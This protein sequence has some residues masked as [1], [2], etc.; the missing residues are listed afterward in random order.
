[1]P[2][3]QNDVPAVAG[4]RDVVGC[5]MPG[6]SAGGGGARAEV[7]HRTQAKQRGGRSHHEGPSQDPHPPPPFPKPRGGS[8]KR[9]DSSCAGYRTGRAHTGITRRST[10][11]QGMLKAIPGVATTA[12]H[13]PAQN[14]PSR[15]RGSHTTRTLPGTQQ[16]PPPLASET[17]DPG[18]TDEACPQ[19]KACT[20]AHP[21]PTSN[22]PRPPPRQCTWA[23]RAQTRGW[24]HL[25]LP[26]M[27]HIT[28]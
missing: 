5:R 20:P 25:T 28:Y 27:Q 23:G 2:K 19:V 16:V 13:P 10:G 26:A 9:R 11:E 12:L 4:R 22:P 15:R 7:T 8:T 1:M 24:P 6:S 3:P 18:C 17:N 21:H 14:T